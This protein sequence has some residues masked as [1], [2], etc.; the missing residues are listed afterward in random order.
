MGENKLKDLMN[1]DLGQLKNKLLKK[2]INEK[3]KPAKKKK[4]INRKIVSFDIGSEFTKIVIGK[5]YNGKLEIEYMDIIETPE[6]VV[7]DGNLVNMPILTNFIKKHL[8]EK[9]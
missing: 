6:E 7:L 8:S 5:Y 9:T 3:K 4:E 2:P 1:M